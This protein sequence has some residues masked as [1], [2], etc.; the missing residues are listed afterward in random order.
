MKRWAALLP[1]VVLVGL[2][3]LFAGYALHHDPHVN[4]AALVGKPAPAVAL[5]PLDG[6]AR[7]PVRRPGQGPVLV[8]FFFSTCVPCIQETPALLALKAQGVP[9]IGIS[10]K[11]D[12]ALSQGFLRSYGNPYSAVYSDRDGRAGVEFGV[13]GAP[14]TFAVSSG[15]KVLDKQSGVL[16]PDRAA[17]LVGRLDR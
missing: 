4:P 1:L 9:I 5:P 8:N 2:A 17:D 7:T 15:G 3:A 12:P 16:T 6:G 11:E 13:T 14:E 10:W